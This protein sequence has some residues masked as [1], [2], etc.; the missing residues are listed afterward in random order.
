[1]GKKEEKDIM[2][3]NS[4]YQVKIKAI[5]DKASFDEVRR[6][7]SQIIDTLSKMDMDEKLANG[8]VK[9]STAATEIQKLQKAYTEAFRSDLGSINIQK[10]N[11]LLAESK[12]RL[13]VVQQAYSALG[14]NGDR[15]F[16]SFATD[17]LTANRGLKQTHTIVDDMITTMGNT[18]KWGISSSVMNSF[19]GA[20]SQA[21]SYVKDLDESLNNIRIVSGQS[22][23]Q[24]AVFAKNAN[25]AAKSL[26]ATTLQYSDAALI[27]YQQGLNDEQV[28][29]M[30]DITI[31]MSNVLGT[32]AEDVS[33]YMTAI[34]NNFY[35]EGGKSLE[36]YADVITKLGA[37]TASSAEEISTGLEKFA[38]IADT[39][40]LSYEY[41]TAA[42]T[43][44]TAT[45]RQ[46][47]EVVGTAFK[48]L[49]ARIQDLE[50]GETLDD[51][52]TLGKYS[53]ALYSV[54][55]N[56]K[57]ASGNL[58]DM[59]DIL[60]EMGSKWDTLTKAQ[61][62][63]LAQTVA[64]TR[65]Y[66]QLVALMDNW[67]YFAE[68]LQTAMDATG[69]LNEQQ[70]IYL[71][72][73]EAHINAANAAWD[74]FKDS[75]IDTD[76]INFFSDISKYLGNFAAFSVDT[77][78]GG[79]STTFLGLAGALKLLNNQMSTGLTD[80]VFNLR[81]VK[82]TAA[83]AR[84]EMETVQMLENANIT[85]ASKEQIQGIINLKKEFLSYGKLVSNEQNEEINALL[86]KKV[87]R[88][89]ELD[90][91][92]ER[93]EETQNIANSVQQEGLSQ[94]NLTEENFTGAK[95][96]DKENE[97]IQDNF[98]A[99][100]NAFIYLKQ[101]ATDYEKLLVDIGQQQLKIQNR[102]LN[103]QDFVEKPGIQKALPIEGAEDKGPSEK[104]QKKYQEQLIAFTD[105]QTQLLKENTQK[106]RT[107]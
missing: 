14:T 103:P 83:A 64:G 12:V 86:K 92:R 13:S 55:I 44:V 19:T 1:M 23:E 98:T 9:V 7:F 2:G 91:I 40:G 3:M 99:A 18:I 57:D 71:D 89:N 107:Q 16:K 42:L 56:I 52:T 85:K 51:G 39:V 66:T 5:T 65:Q 33:N 37:A 69:S 61:Q 36:Y 15:L 58:K 76:V 17:I 102:I 26:G 74:D 53:E 31:K 48:T 94:I 46:S 72:S 41:A 93:L 6:S 22:A 59:D 29:Q 50:I 105:R 35:E 87:L 100:E 80:I 77:L 96:V 79:L 24:M 82:D 81:S 62:V 106:Y 43:T 25:N 90:Q 88:E 54:G 49:F 30:T 75:L 21:A 11:N 47:A 101:Q 104:E 68:N 38:A 8:K 4:D 32:N 34:W 70:Q 95:G 73:T 67:D 84:A 28:K 27:Y 78:G 97:S 45:T 10:F 60:D 20:V 63:S